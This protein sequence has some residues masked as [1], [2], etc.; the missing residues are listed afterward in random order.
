MSRT[1]FPRRL[2]W[3]AAI[4]LISV[5]MLALVSLGLRYC[6]ALAGLVAP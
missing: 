5:G 4:W 3:L 1:S 6:M 2:A